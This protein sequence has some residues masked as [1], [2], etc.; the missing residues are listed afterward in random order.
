VV[1][2]V[3]CGT[4]SAPLGSILVGKAG[5]LAHDVDR[6]PSLEDSTAFPCARVMVGTQQ[7]WQRLLLVR[8]TL[9]VLADH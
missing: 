3:A 8:V 5:L 6:N 9:G 7:A 2:V 4:A 1:V